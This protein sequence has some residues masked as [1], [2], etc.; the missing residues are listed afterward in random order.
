MGVIMNGLRNLFNYS[1]K[2][3][4][5]DEI[6][7]E[8]AQ[9]NS[10]IRGLARNN[11]FYVSV[12]KSYRKGTISTGFNIQSKT[13]NDKFNTDFEALIKEWSKK[14]NC[15]ITGRFFF[16]QAQR[17]MADEYAV[18]GG[19][20]IIY[21]HFS[22][23]F[24]HGYM[25]ELIPTYLIDTSKHV[26]SERT[27]NG[28]VKNKN[29][30]ITHIWL[31]RDSSRTYPSY[32]V[33]YK[34][35]TLNTNAW[36]DVLQYTA[37]SP[38][39]P[40]NESQ[41]YIDAYKTSEL[42]GSQKLSSYPLFIKTALI[43]K[44]IKAK[45]KKI[46]EATNR[47]V[48]DVIGD[49]EAGMY[50]LMR[51]ERL[52][53]ETPFAYLMD[54]EEIHETGKSRDNIYASMYDNET[55]QQ[56]AG[57]GLTASS[58]VDAT[59]SSYTE[60]LR[61]SQSEEGEFAITAQ[62][63]VEGSLREMIEEKLLTGL[64]MVGKINAPGYWENPAPYR[65]TKFLRQVAGHVDPIKNSKSRTEDLANG[66]KT[67]ISIL[68]ADKID[69]EVHLKELETYQMAKLESLKNV[70]KAY[71]DAGIIYPNSLESTITESDLKDDE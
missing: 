29:G 67:E 1:A 11:P 8:A 50:D 13:L 25:F 46:A 32:K 51:Q 53:I 19:G 60:T 57:V 14:G 36:D 47:K 27:Y 4:Y 56:S 6:G 55:R 22:P 44:V 58:T 7:S 61:G 28:I 42:K 38:L 45:A 30:E 16:E 52:N 21:H 24:T 33:P 40:I 20:Y 59:A 3:Q 15:E 62:E 18:K 10:Y 34:H 35:L 63:I 70:K 43:G 41:E 48:S 9:T 54:D 69:Y 68:A 5:E 64:M 26:I 23:L 49:T 2:D 17:S 71:E 39:S 65:N 37:T 66:T 12:S 31:Y